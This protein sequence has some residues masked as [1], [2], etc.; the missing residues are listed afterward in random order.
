MIDIDLTDERNFI[1]P[2]SYDFYFTENGDIA[3]I[4]DFKISLLVAIF[5]DRDKDINLLGQEGSYLWKLKQSRLTTEIIN[6]YRFYVHQALQ[7]LYNNL[8]I[9]DIDIKI[10]QDNKVQVNINLV[11]SNNSKNPKNY[12]FII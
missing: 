1:K 6:Q 10:M 3:I 2:I 12:T 9:E 11:N 5:G 7:Y 8:L 4:E